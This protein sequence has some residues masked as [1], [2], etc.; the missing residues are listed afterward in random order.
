MASIKKVNLDKTNLQTHH[1][2]GA[3]PYSGTP[4][5]DQS[6]IAIDPVGGSSAGKTPTPP[7]ISNGMLQKEARSAEG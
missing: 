5:S 6:G 7:P 2:V 1:F 3:H 4:A